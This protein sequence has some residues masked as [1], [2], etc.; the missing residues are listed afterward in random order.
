[1]AGFLLF[2]AAVLALA[3]GDDPEHAARQRSL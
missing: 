3:A 2:L 1:M